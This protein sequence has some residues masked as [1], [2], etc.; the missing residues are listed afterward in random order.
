MN[1]VELIKLDIV[2]MVVVKW[3]SVVN[4]LQ[5]VIIN[6]TIGGAVVR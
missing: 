6:V 2:V 4:P 5:A 1:V 3:M